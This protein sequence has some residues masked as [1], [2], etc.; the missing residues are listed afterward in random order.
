MARLTSPI[1]ASERLFLSAEQTDE[2]LRGITRR[3]AGTNADGLHFCMNLGRVLNSLFTSMDKHFAHVGITQGR[4]VI[5]LH[6]SG[7]EAGISPSELAAR[8]G[9]S[10][11]AMSKLVSGLEKQGYAQ[12]TAAPTDRRALTVQLTP[13][14]RTFLD[15]TMPADQ[16]KLAGIMQQFSTPERQELLRLVTKVA[17][18]F[19]T[20]S[21][22]EANEPPIC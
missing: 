3:Y 22:E 7:A 4:L 18:L 10:R 17:Q 20:A 9:V 13:A 2:V 19:Q 14:G 16:R 12:R 21:E 8:C 15:E 6:L 1:A 11:A 5:L